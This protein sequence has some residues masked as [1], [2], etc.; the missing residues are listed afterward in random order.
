MRTEK[1][2]GEK[3]ERNNNQ[4][5]S[6]KNIINGRE[7]EEKKKNGTGNEEGTTN[8]RLSEEKRGTRWK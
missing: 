3:E 4:R 2:I 6:E 8:G 7:R 5:E 1:I